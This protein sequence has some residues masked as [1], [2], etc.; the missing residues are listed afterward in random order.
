MLVEAD[1]LSKDNSILLST[2]SPKVFNLISQNSAEELLIY[3]ITESNL[4]G[5]L[6][7]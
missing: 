7:G 5:Y 6:N 4:K 1:F 2:L 3:P